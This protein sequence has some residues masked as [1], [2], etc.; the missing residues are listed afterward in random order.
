MKQ[1]QSNESG[2]STRQGK[3]ASYGNCTMDAAPEQD[4]VGCWWQRGRHHG[5]DITGL[6]VRDN[7]EMMQAV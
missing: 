6:W 1:R 3:E 4:H 2:R 5:E 7:P